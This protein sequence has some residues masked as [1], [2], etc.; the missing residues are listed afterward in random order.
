MKYQKLI[1]LIEFS[2]FNPNFMVVY[3]LGIYAALHN[4]SPAIDAD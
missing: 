2:V 3:A 4:N 1:A